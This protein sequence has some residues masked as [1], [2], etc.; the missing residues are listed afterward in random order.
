[1]SLPANPPDIPTR[2]QR[3][4]AIA[5]GWLAAL[6]LSVIFWYPLWTG[7][8]LV[9]SDVYAYGLPQKAYFVQCLRAGELPLW[10]N[11]VG[12]G[13][14][15]LAESQTGVFYPL[16]LALYPFLSLNA[17][18]S[19]SVIVHYVLAFVFAV[20]Y[21]RRAGLA[22]GGA[23]LAALV[24]TYGWFPPRVCLEWAIIGG[25]WL[26][27][28]LWCV[29]SYLQTGWWRYAFL[30]TAALAMQMLAGHFM[31]A[32]ITQLTLAGYVPLRLWFS[33]RDPPDETHH[34]RGRMG[35][36][37]AF[38]VVGAFP[39]VAVQLL[40]TWELKQLSQRATAAGEHD[41]AMGSIPPAYFSQI[42]V[43]WLWYPDESSF[44]GAVT[45]GTPRTN[46][47]EA[48][49]YF[50]LIPLPLLLWGIWCAVRTGDRRLFN[51]IILGVVGLV[52]AGGWLVPVTRHLP[53]FSYFQGTGRYG[54]ITTLA[55]GL[56]AGSGFDHIL[57]FLVS[58]RRAWH[59]SVP[60][61]WL[62][63]G[64]FVTAV[65]A[66]TAADLYV[67]SR[68]VT[69]AAI[70]NDPP[71]NHIS[72]S[73]VRR[74][75]LKFSQPPRILSEGKNLPSLLG[76]ATVPTY[77]GLG[78]LQYYD[79]EFTLPEPWPFHTRPTREQRDWLRR[80]GV[81][82][83]L[84]FEPI[85]RRAW[86]ARLVWEGADYFLNAALARRRDERLYLYELEGSR[87]RAAFLDLQPGSSV[88]I[89]DYLANQ[90]VIVTRSSAKAQVVLT[91]LAYPGWSVTVDGNAVN[92]L[93]VDGMY[94][95]VEVP[96]GEHVVTWMFRPPTLYWGAG[97]SLATAIL[98]LAVAHLRFW[99]PWAFER[100]A[101]LIRSHTIHI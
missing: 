17:A 34:S 11:L 89:S 43:P 27:L 1:V 67:V 98:L 60:A 41:P 81:T 29:E 51:W 15:Q 39:L 7:G 16:H 9:G 72:T 32:F 49:L 4:L 37:L 44:D 38:A 42:V 99:H 54:V 82:H 53:G 59:L 56:L 69:Y 8:G 31:L 95:G 97:I 22:S 45:P 30:L 65:F 33:R 40:P 26:P 21:A 87:G 46:R 77:L 35:L 92:P 3:T 75:L 84:S 80:A 73:P 91:D 58:R 61:A 24:Y 25:A 79:S 6:L 70:V 68:L 96:S 86:S 76:V 36:G 23:L 74:E 47:V 19:A 52:L 20:M 2:G 83:Y 5:G 57:D 18:Y 10:N 14:P 13:Y 50:G 88:R 64:C 85:D 28:A 101:G 93:T 63:S 100:H 71:A 90:V 66:G 55:G 78:P 48:H 62:S 12:N 94:R